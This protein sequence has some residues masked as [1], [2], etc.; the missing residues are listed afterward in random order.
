M[1]NFAKSFFLTIFVF[2]ENPIAIQSSLFFEVFC[3]TVNSM[4][5]ASD[6]DGLQLASYWQLEVQS[7]G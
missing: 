7:L 3:L 2:S 5:S 1:Q 4:E 6:V